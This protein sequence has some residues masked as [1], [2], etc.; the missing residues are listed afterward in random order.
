MFCIVDDCLGPAG[1]EFSVVEDG[2]VDESYQDEDIEVL[3]GL[4]EPGDVDAVMS[5]S[6]WS[7]GCMERRADNVPCVEGLRCPG[8]CLV[9]AKGFCRHATDVSCFPSSFLSR[10]FGVGKR[11]LAEP[12]RSPCA[13]GVV[14]RLH[15]TRLYS[16][17]EFISRAWP[18][19]CRGSVCQHACISASVTGADKMQGWSCPSALAYTPTPVDDANPPCGVSLC[20]KS[21]R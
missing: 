16:V 4:W 19:S 17:H 3:V 12:G 8:G 15:R 11:T 13:V 7:P 5:P 20:C 9:G 2:E 1:C 14:L 18:T 21:H 6:P 10:V